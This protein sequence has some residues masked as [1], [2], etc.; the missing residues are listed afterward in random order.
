M[1]RPLSP[2]PLLIALMYT[3][4]LSASVVLCP[5]VYSQE[6]A[7][8]PAGTPES[9]I[10]NGNAAPSPGQSPR[11]AP[12]AQGLQEQRK[13]NIFGTTNE[14]IIMEPDPVT[15]DNIIQVTPPRREEPEQQSPNMLLIQPEIKVRPR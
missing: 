4:L 8:P 3:I 10:D 2:R 9:T 5:N 11:T 15:G 1:I 13:D 12:D 14:G 7:P 6:L